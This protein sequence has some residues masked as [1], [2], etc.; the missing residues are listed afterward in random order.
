MADNSQQ[1]PSLPPQVQDRGLRVFCRRCQ[2]AY[3][4]DP[5]YDWRLKPTPPEIADWV[6]KLAEAQG[7]FYG[8]DGHSLYLECGACTEQNKLA[9]EK[10]LPRYSTTS[11]CPACGGK[12]VGTQFCRG[13]DLTCELNARR[14]HLHRTCKRCK[15]VWIEGCLN[16]SHTKGNE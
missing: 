9:L 11:I 6:V 1:L 8:R 16:D 12:D 15:Y 7:W 2:R 13:L 5:E 3:L 4:Q 10:T 14:D